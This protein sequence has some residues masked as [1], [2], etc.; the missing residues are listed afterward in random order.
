MALCLANSL[1]VCRD[2]IL[3]DQL[4]RYKWW[5]NFGYMSSTG[6]CFD[7][8][9]ATSQ[10]LQEFERRQRQFASKH[11]IRPEHLDRISD[12]SLLDEFEVFCK[13]SNNH[14][15]KYCIYYNDRGVKYFIYYNNRIVK[16]GIY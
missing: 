9:G 12:P 10:S 8:G 7:I 2:F 5:Y 14:S 4:V 1:V 15:L 16:N 3:Y 11:Q 6:K 13:Y